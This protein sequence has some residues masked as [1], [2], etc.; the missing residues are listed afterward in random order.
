MK[1]SR[2][3]TLFLALG[4]LTPVFR[5]SAQTTEQR[6]GD[7]E[8]KLDA[9]LAEIDRLKMSGATSD[10][11][12]QPVSRYGFS[13]AASRVYGLASGSSIGGYG[14]MLLE[15]G[16][17]EREDGQPIGTNARA[18]MLR[19][20]LYVGHKFTSAL[21]FNSEI[22]FEHG[23]I[24][25]EAEVVVDPSSGEGSAELTGEVV[26]EFAYLDWQAKPW[27]GVR[28]GKVLVPMG[29][30]NEQHEPPVFPGARRPDS[31]RMIV[32]GT[33]AA[34]G[35]G[36][37][38]TTASGLDWRA[39][40]VEGLDAAHF[41]ASSTVRGGRQSGSQARFTHPALTGRADWKG[42][43]GLTLGIS[44][45]SGDSWQRSQPGGPSLSVRTSL[46]DVHGDY[47]WRAFQ[48]R[49][50]WASGNIGQASELSD[51]LGLTGSDRLGE[52]FAGGYAEALF[53]VASVAWPG[54]EWSLSPYA[55]YETYDT[56]NSVPGGSEDPANEREIM[57][58][59]VVVKP[60]PSVV[61]KADRE[62]RSN[63]ANTET[64][65][66]N[67]ALGWLF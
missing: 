7:V 9:A 31:E 23:G 60:H 25:D 66:W 32:P 43:E 57:T 12:K 22:E 30:V 47:R 34:N 61:L 41:S 50:L 1:L 19:A 51:A 56:Q 62:F 26:L 8:K 20:V 2:L 3:L 39:Y 4:L 42:T 48:L 33:W 55:R 16:D 38:G 40:L 58:F 28:A 18:D 63:Q 24:G 29:L 36:F 59:G 49:G 17:R 15:R 14:E 65:R 44:G 67:M 53:D 11:M 21:L 10:T 13:P 35:A 6:L 45:Y 54:S 64:S 52:R 46:F 27:L 37:Y 5:A